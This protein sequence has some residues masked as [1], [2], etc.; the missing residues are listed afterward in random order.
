MNSVTAKMGALS[1]HRTAG[2]LALCHGKSQPHVSR[3]EADTISSACVSR[4]EADTISSA[5]V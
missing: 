5:C 3:S 1:P 4:S 2:R